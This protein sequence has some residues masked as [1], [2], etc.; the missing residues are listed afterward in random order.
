[1]KTMKQMQNKTWKL[2]YIYCDVGWGRKYYSVTKLPLTQG[3]VSD[4]I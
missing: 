1:M 3:T 4:H 2:G